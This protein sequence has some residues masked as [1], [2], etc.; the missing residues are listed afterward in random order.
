MVYWISW[1]ECSEREIPVLTSHTARYIQTWISPQKHRRRGYNLQRHSNI[2]DI[3]VSYTV[4]MSN[5]R[6]VTNYCSFI[7]W[8]LTCHLRSCLW[9]KLAYFFFTLYW[10]NYC[11]AHRPPSLFFVCIVLRKEGQINEKLIFI[12]KILKKTYSKFENLFFPKKN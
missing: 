2:R 10:N 11:V 3:F 1:R 9:M 5:W 4:I 8:T 12:S 6:D 7:T